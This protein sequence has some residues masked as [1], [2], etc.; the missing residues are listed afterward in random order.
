MNEKKI[1]VFQVAGTYVGTIVGAGFASGQE[2]LQFFVSFGNL[3]VLG[4]F[5]VSILF[6]YLGYLIMD[7]GWELNASSHL[8]IVTKIGG[9]FAGAFQIL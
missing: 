7:L 2:I 3:G 9:R 5:I 6:I 4:I 8:P 1:T